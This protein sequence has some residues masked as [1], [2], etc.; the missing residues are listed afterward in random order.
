MQPKVR[1]MNPDHQRLIDDLLADPKTAMCPICGERGFWDNREGKKN[2]KS[3]DY[4][5][6]NKEC[7]GA[8]PLKGK[9]PYAVWLPEG[10][11]V[12]PATPSKRLTGPSDGPPAI[13]A[14]SGVPESPEGVSEAFTPDAVAAGVTAKREILAAAYA[15]AYDV[16]GAVQLEA[17][18]ERGHPAPDAVSIQAGAATLLIAAQNRGAI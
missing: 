12:T 16:A 1:P 17:H 6:R 5:C 2:P 7:P 15:W 18:A 3:P 9:N 14:E 8:T 4:K 10:Y 13:H 11:P